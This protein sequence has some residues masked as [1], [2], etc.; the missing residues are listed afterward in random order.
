MAH[1]YWPIVG[2]LLS[3]FEAHDGLSPAGTHSQ[4]EN[5]VRGGRASG[6]TMTPATK[7]AP[8]IIKVSL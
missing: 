3:T 2:L 1:T 7:T 8:I 5:I 6:I 4:R